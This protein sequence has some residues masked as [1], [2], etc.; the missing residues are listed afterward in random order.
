MGKESSRER[1]A[2]NGGLKGNNRESILV[3]MN[4][5]WVERDDEVNL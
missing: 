3:K 1:V 2:N 4:Q 5:L